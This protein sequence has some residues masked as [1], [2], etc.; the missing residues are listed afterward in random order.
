[1]TYAL[2]TAKAKYL[3]TSPASISVAAEAAANAGIPKARIFLLSG[4]TPGYTTIQDLISAGRAYGQDQVPA[5]RLSAGKKS[6]DVCAFLSFS[7]GTTGAPKAVMIA[8]QNVIAQCLQIQQLTPDSH[9]KVLAV[10]PLFH[11]TGL[12]HT[13]QLPILINAEVIMLPT[14]TMPS[15][16]ATVQKYQ[17]EELLLVPPILIRLLRDPVV[18][19]YDLSCVKRFSSGAAPLSAE[20]LSL[21]EKKF[22]GTGFKQGYGMTESCSCITA[23][24]PEFYG[25]NHAFA[26]G[27]IVASTSVR[28]L[29]E[30]GSDG[31]VGEAGE[32]LAKGPQCV[33]GYLDNEKATK[34]TFDSDGWLHTGDQGYVDEMGLVYM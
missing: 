6:K 30:D 13:L 11:I 5:F 3:A 34:E 18:D 10:L 20:V 8:H 15:M 19:E 2:K 21:L 28:F 26:V 27:T 32:I 7:S 23:H 25:Y 29:K 1:M 12:E 24:P 33:M 14:F 9:K 17:I 16:L 31:G 22:P 4:E